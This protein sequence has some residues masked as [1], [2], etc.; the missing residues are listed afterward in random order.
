[1][2]PFPHM[3]KDRLQYFKDRLLAEKASLEDDLRGLGKVDASGDWSAVPAE[4]TD[5]EGDPADQADFVEEFDSKIARLG[6]LE[7][8][9]QEVVRALK[10]IED[11]TY[12]VCIKS[13]NPIEED[14]LEAN[15]AAE[16]CKAMMNS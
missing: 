5:V 11:G 4:H 10:H 13:G 14:R 2:L 3:K 16:T 1:M 8:R 7:T 15:P 12:G 9:Y 6:S